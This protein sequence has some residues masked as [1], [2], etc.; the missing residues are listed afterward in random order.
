MT[1]EQAQEKAMQYAQENGYIKTKYAGK[2]EGFWYFHIV[3]DPKRGHYLGLPVY[4]KVQEMTGGIIMSDGWD[5]Y[6][7]A[8]KQESLL[9]KG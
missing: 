1:F 8:Q 7:W 3:R 9:N 5:E 4:I 2:R 6:L